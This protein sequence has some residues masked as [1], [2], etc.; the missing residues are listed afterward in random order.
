MSSDPKAILA[1]IPARGGSKGIPRKNLLPLAGKPLL[2]HS[3]L[4]AKNSPSI[5]RVVVSTDDREIAAVAVEWGAEVVLRPVELSGDT[6]SSE[7]ALVHVLDWLKQKEG[8]ES[9]LVVFLQVTS[10]CRRPD[11]VEMAI[12]ALQKENADSLLSVGPVQGFIW[13]VEK[14]G[15]IH[16]FS[17]DHQHRPRRQDAPE[18]LIENGSIYVF[19]PWVL[20][21]FNNRLGGKVAL[22]RMSAFDSF[23]IDEPG[24]FELLEL[25]M[26]YRGGNGQPEQREARISEEKPCPRLQD[27]GPG[28][29]DRR[30]EF[31]TTGQ[32]TDSG[33]R[34][35]VLRLL[36]PIKLLVLDFDGVL[37]D[38]RVLVGQ[39]SSESVLCHRGDGL[40]IE[41]LKQTNIEACVLSKET[42]PVV[43]AR[44]GKLGLECIQGCD[45]KLTALR[46]KAKARYLRS[47]EVAYMGNDVNDLDCMRWVG[48]PIAVADATD[49]VKTVARWVTTQRGGHGAVR[50]VCELVVKARTHAKS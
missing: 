26:R 13:R 2:A 12:E 28:Q 40:G 27:Y 17:Y 7:S 39:D 47:D 32:I 41:M 38:N 4:Q 8:Y 14:E 30:E 11:E 19:K 50:E 49:E 34:S 23:Q 6:A 21:Q 22:H 25:I 9:E 1:I 44:C 29:D 16:S 42:N 46:Q 35:T 24:D 3:I 36:S 45:D 37:T 33:H 31:D 43:A 5:S 48:L 15:R 18:D 20:R 10:P